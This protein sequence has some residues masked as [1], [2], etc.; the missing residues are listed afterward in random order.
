MSFDNI[1]SAMMMLYDEL[2]KDKA[3]KSLIKKIDAA[4]SDKQLKEG[5]VAGVNRLREL[6]K[7]NLA[8]D[9]VNK[10]KGFAF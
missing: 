8:D 9:I 4:E 10:A 2:K 3:S 1:G 5:L 7:N 6:G